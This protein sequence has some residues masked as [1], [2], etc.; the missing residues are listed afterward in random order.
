[1]DYKDYYKT[2]GVPRTATQAEIKKAFRKLARQHHPDQ[3]KGDK[4]AEQR[5]KDINEANEVLS[6]PAKRKQYDE[7]GANWEAYSRMGG[8]GAGG[9]GGANPFAGFAGFGQPGQGGVRYEFRTAGNAEDFSDFFR[10]FFS[11]GA[12]ADA[13]AG[14]GRR[15][16]ARSR[17]STGGTTIEDLLGQMGASGAAFADEGPAAPRGRLPAVEAEA[18]ITLEEAFNGTKRLIDVD[19][20]RLEVTIPRGVD[21]GSRIRLT[22]KG[23][24]GRDL[25]IVVKVKPDPTFTRNGADLTRE[26]RVTLREALLGGEIP[27]RTLKGRV[28]LTIPPGT[29]NGRTFRLAGQGMPRLKGD[30]TGDL[31]VRIV[32]VL[33]TGLSDA[34]KRAANAFLDLVEQ[35]DPRAG[36]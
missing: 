9:A 6:D 32:V 16:S 8:A 18:E 29:Q 19:G 21:T 35:P 11:G 22:G 24:G 30:G 14:T 34:A 23:P 25:T 36:S 28:L 4:G 20:K 13:T 31:Y 15:T 26:V 3:N 10:M 27:V 17:P 12:A 5:F 33:P 2:L 1:M 7:L